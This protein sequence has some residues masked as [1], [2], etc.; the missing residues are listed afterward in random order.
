MKYKSSFVTAR[1]KR[2]LKKQR[3]YQLVIIV[4]G[5]TLMWLSMAIP[6]VIF[7]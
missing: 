1:Q 5:T 7:S 2:L 3:N 4:V 6:L